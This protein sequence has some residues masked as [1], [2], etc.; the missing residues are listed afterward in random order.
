MNNRDAGVLARWRAWRRWKAQAHFVDLR[1]PIPKSDAH[2]LYRMSGRRLTII[3]NRA[4]IHGITGPDF[5]IQLVFGSGPRDPAPFV[6]FHEPFAPDLLIDSL[7]IGLPFEA[8]RRSYPAIVPIGDDTQP[9]PEQPAS[10]VISRYLGRLSDGKHEF[11]ADVR[12]GRVD[13]FE[14]GVLGLSDARRAA[15]RG[16]RDRQKADEERRAQR[17]QAF[18]NLAATREDDDAM[19]LA[20]ASDIKDGRRLAMF[21]KAQATS[22]DWHAVATTW[23]WDLGLAPLFWIIRR[24]EC[25]LATAMEVFVGGEPSFHAEKFTDADEVPD[26]CLDSFLLTSEIF[27][28]WRVGFYRRSDIAFAAPAMRPD[29]ALDRLRKR[30]EV[31]EAMMASRQGYAVSTEGYAEGFPPRDRLPTEA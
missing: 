18:S 19:L 22:N 30:H 14:I 27:E 3:G 26:W 9:H 5:G 15:I 10:A 6:R 23:N 12:D 1:P 25:D 17:K 7:R 8:L 16:H 2:R 29:H 4:D 13:S 24:P 31:P 20:W 28:R 21:L 11:V